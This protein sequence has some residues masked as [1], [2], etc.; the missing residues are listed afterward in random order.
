LGKFKGLLS[1]LQG[2]QKI[3]IANLDIEG[4]LNCSEGKAGQFSIKGN[5]IVPKE[6][7]QIKFSL[8]FVDTSP[9]TVVDTLVGRGEFAVKQQAGPLEAMSFSAALDATGAS[10]SAG[11]HLTL[12]ASVKQASRGEEYALNFASLDEWGQSVQL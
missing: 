10:L 11:T 1:Y 5:N 4:K 9:N 3:Q 7:G 8:D 12:D 6:D 2:I